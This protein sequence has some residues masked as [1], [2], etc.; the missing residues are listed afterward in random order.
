M[1][2]AGFALTIALHAVQGEGLAVVLFVW[3]LLNAFL[4]TTRT[5]AVS[6]RYNA[7]RAHD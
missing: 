6:C 1:L 3:T 7:C 4:L 5:E 2:W